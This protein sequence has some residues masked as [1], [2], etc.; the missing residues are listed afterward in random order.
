MNIKE[1]VFPVDFSQGSVD[2]C[3]YV[4][5]VTR[6][7]GAKLT[8]IH[9][10]E[11]PSA[12]ALSGNEASSAV[13]ASAERLRIQAIAALEAFQQQ[14]IPHIDSE[15]RVLMGEPAAAIVAYAGDSSEK[16][17]VMPTRGYGPFRQMLLGSVTAK[18][19]HDAK[20]PV[21]TGPHLDRAI[22]PAERFSLHRI[23]CAVSLNWETDR[24]LKFSTQLA[25]QL[26]LEL[27]AFHVVSPL[28]EGMLPLCAPSNPPLS[29]ANARSALQQAVHGAGGLGAVC[30]TIGEVSREVARAAR[31]H[32]ADLVVIGRGG[33]PEAP[34]KL[35]SHAYAIVRR[36]PC[37]VLCI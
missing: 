19:L 22:H 12:A 25:R 31:T 7:F 24:L 37:P 10:V 36:A 17:I 8:L 13:V 18:V 33:A 21:L 5:A 15:V 28:E 32:N 26:G 9:V 16:M 11:T 3:P 23:L 14:Y 1:I 6:R 4:A 35:G 20:C 34:G 30:V 29:T 2:A 27:T